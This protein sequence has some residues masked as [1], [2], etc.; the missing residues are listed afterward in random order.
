MTLR[1][2]EYGIF[3][4]HR[5]R[6]RVLPSGYRRSKDLIIQSQLNLP[7]PRI[8]P[9]IRR[10]WR[11][12]ELSDF[13][14]LPNFLQVDSERSSFLDAFSRREA[15]STGILSALTAAIRIPEKSA[16]NFINLASR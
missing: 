4:L 16:T 6:R 9:I 11:V 3:A 10:S 14:P 13:R 2:S 8:D 1:E 5:S 15:K 12:G 7:L